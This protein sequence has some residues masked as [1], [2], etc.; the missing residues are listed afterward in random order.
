[1]PIMDTTA[2]RVIRVHEYASR[3][4]EIDSALKRAKGQVT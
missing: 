1:M 2:S 3:R 4:H